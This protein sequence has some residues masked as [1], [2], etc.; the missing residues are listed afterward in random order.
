MSSV[1]ADHYEC[2][3]AISLALQEKKKDARSRVGKFPIFSLS[4]SFFFFLKPGKGG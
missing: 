1:A 2:L 4:L 3:H